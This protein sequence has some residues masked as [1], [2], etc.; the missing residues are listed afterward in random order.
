MI[1]R[2]DASCL[3]FFAYLAGRPMTDAA[4]ILK[5]RYPFL[6]LTPYWR[7]SGYTN[8]FLKKILVSAMERM[9]RIILT[10]ELEAG[11]TAVVPHY[12]DASLVAKG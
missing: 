5:L 4:S 1:I 12:L 2:N 6:L 3:R 8:N 7:K 9:F 10:P 11:F